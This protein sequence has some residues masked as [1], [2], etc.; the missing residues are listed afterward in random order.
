MNVNKVAQKKREA[1]QR[2]AHS[3]LLRRFRSQLPFTK[4]QFQTATGWGKGNT[5][6]TY[7]TKQFQTLLIPVNGNQFR[8]GEVF[9]RFTPWEKFRLH[10]TQKRGV[11]SDYTNFGFETV[12]VFEFFMP[13]TNEGYLRSSLDAL[14]Y[15]DSIISRLHRVELA[16]LQTMFSPKQGESDVRYLERLCKWLSKKFGGY[17]ISHVNGRFR[18]SDLKNLEDAYAATARQA[19]R[20]L[21]D[22]TTAV[23]RFIFPCGKPK[24]NRFDSPDLLTQ[25]A[26]QTA[27]AE[28]IAEATKIRFFFNLLFVQ[29]IVE[30]VNGEDQIWLLESGFQNRLYIWRVQNER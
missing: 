3:F 22:E 13:L 16:T 20:Y 8:V 25:R 4:T 9:R 28:L 11:A 10:V 15:K 19:G 21:V 2:K 18:A 6:R 12:M 17:S 24:M 23:V 27:S 1:H 7:W 30:V 5:F 14:F 29:S 26:T